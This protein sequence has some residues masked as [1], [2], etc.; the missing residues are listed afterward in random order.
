MTEVSPPE[1]SRVSALRTAVGAAGRTRV[2]LR[3]E[4][5]RHD[6]RDR[7]GAAGVDADDRSRSGAAGRV[8]KR[9][10]SNWLERKMT[11]GRLGV[12]IGSGRFVVENLRIDGMF[13]N[14]PPWLEVK[15]LDVVADVERAAAPRSAA[16]FDRDD[17]LED[18]RRVVSRRPPD[19]SAPDRSAAPAAHRPA[20]WSSRRCS[21]S[22][23]TAA[24]WCSTTTDRT[25]AR[26]RPT[27]MSP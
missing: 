22:T 11:I 26:S 4:V 23:R 16:R 17:R 19:I 5:C 10:G 27:S 18:D 20:R 1:M 2:S 21:T 15:R 9:E 3:P 12:H 8:R 13:P 6:R 24:S 25:G 14:E 7:R